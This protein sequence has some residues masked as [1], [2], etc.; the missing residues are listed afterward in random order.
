MSAV[1]S[2]VINEKNEDASKVE[3]YRLLGEGYKAMQESRVTPLE[4]VIKK[5]EIRNSDEELEDL[6]VRILASYANPQLRQLEEEAFEHA[7]VEK[8]GKG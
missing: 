1:E 4:E 6:P 8:H 7:M 3:L 2:R 5:I